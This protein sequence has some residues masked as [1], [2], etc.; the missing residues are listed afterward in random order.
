MISIA[1][2]RRKS[3]RSIQLSQKRKAHSNGSPR[4]RSV[5]AWRSGSSAGTNSLPSGE[6]TPNPSSTAERIPASQNLVL[7]TDTLTVAA[8]LSLHPVQTEP[9]GACCFV[10]QCLRLARTNPAGYPAIQ[11]AS[12]KVRS[13]LLSHLPS[14]PPLG[15][16]S[17]EGPVAVQRRH[18]L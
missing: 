9:I 13:H 2:N 8:M 16:R 14:H 4:I 17:Q 10:I 15:H 6:D 5:S 12:P 1:S 18:P 7:V 11:A 3:S